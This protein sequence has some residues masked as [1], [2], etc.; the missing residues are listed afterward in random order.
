M[1]DIDARLDEILSYFIEDRVRWKPT[2]Q[3]CELMIIP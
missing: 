3:T 1:I 2:Q